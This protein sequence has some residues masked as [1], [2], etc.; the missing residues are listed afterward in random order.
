M[1]AIRISRTAIVICAMVAGPWTPA[2][3]AVV[4]EGKEI[5]TAFYFPDQNTIGFGGVPVVSTVGPGVEIQA[6]PQGF[7]IASI[8]FDDTSITLDFFVSLNGTV[9]PFN[10]WRFYDASGTI[11][12]FTG[13]RLTTALPGWSVSYDADDIWL[14]GS[15]STYTAGS[16]L[17]IDVAAVPE[18]AACALMGLGLVVVGAAR[19]CARAQATLRCSVGAARRLA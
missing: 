8:D 5:T 4:L 9:A 17:R 10:G 18:P 15:G 13:A 2:A 3:R 6:S 16:S 1:N 11:P 12:A 7:P 19:R 14:N